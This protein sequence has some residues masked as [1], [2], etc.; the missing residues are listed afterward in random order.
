MSPHARTGASFDGLCALVRQQPQYAWLCP[1][2]IGVVA[3]HARI[4]VLHAGRAMPCAP[5]ENSQLYTVLIGAV[6]LV[7][8]DAAVPSVGALL[9]AVGSAAAMHTAAMQMQ[10]LKAGLSGVAENVTVD[11][12]AVNGSSNSAAVA[13]TIAWRRVRAAAEGCSARGKRHHTNGSAS[14]LLDQQQCV[15]SHCCS[16]HADDGLEHAAQAAEITLGVAVAG[17]S[18]WCGQMIGGFNSIAQGS[19]SEASCTSHV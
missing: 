19:T 13:T 4:L 6:C 3:A 15:A 9:E 17:Q 16:M 12:D 2:A 5:E 18:F 14:A 10:D 11:D 8:G 7:H 1:A